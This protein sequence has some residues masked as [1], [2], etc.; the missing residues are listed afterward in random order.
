MM[1]IIITLVYIFIVAFKPIH[2]IF[3][4]NNAVLYMPLLY[5]LRKST[6]LLK[7]GYNGV[8]SL[9]KMKE[10]RKGRQK[11]TTKNNLC[12][13]LDMVPHNKDQNYKRQHY[14]WGL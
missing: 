3:C 4:V 6:S 11:T 5:F 9:Q 2:I 10:K 12:I 8:S 1:N 14:N 7:W 13:P